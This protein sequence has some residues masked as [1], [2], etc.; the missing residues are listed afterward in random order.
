MD[1]MAPDHPRPLL[2]AAADR[3]RERRA[4]CDDDNMLPDDPAG[5]ARYVRTHRR[6][7]KAVLA[8]D[9]EDALVIRRALREESDRE[10]LGAI[11]AARA[12]GIT[13]ARIGEI[14]GF[15]G[16]QGSKEMAARLEAAVLPDGH[17]DARVARARRRA[18]CEEAWLLRRHDVIA[19]CVQRVVASSP[20]HDQDEGLADAMAD[21]AEAHGDAGST[22]RQLLALLSLVVQAHDASSP[23]GPDDLG[24]APLATARRLI[25]E[26]PRA[27]A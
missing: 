5:V 4:A 11:Q 25:G 26:W 7:P 17:R 20:H 2:E 14:W 19:R 1:I 18:A 24:C 22:P 10:D 15:R 13:W 23:H 6:V 16:R 9:M 8:A 12:C 21:L 3:I 27:S